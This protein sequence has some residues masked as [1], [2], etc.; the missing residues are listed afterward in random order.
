MRAQGL[1]WNLVNRKPRKKNSFEDLDTRTKLTWTVE[2]FLEVKFNTS[3]RPED[4]IR[5]EVDK[6]QI[7]SNHILTR[8]FCLHD[9]AVNPG[10]PKLKYK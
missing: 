5:K 10:G 8:N 2:N 3:F 6:D 9:E 7:F 1:F 4:I